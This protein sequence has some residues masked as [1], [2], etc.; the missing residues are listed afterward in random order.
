MG[1]LVILIRPKGSSFLSMTSAPIPEGLLDLL[2]RQPHVTVATGIIIQSLGNPLQSAAGVDLTEFNRMSGGFR[3][4]QG[5]PFQS[6]DDILVDEVFARENNVKA[7]EILRGKVLNLDWRVC[8][9]V[10]PGKLNRVFI[11]LRRMQ[12]LT[13]NTAKLSQIYLKVDQPENTGP[14]KESLQRLLEDYPIYSMDEFISLF[15]VD[16]IPALNKFLAIMIGIAVVIGFAVVCLSM[17]M[18]VLQRTREIGIL[19]SLGASRLFILRLI[20]R[21]AVLLALAGTL[22]G[23]GMSFGA[24]WALD[25]FAPASLPPAIVPEWWWKAAGIA[26]AGAMLGAL[27]PGWRAASQDPIEALAYE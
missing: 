7:G 2:R 20:L 15:Q 3:Y 12:D 16:N 1:A 11:D 8:G 25:T 23:I 24:N 22:I 6:P 18:A 21:E 17:Y 13:G 14:V 10:E 27:Y 9:V 19:K 5:G 4:L 26:L